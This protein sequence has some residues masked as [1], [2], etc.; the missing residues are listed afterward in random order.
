V[1]VL[2]PCGVGRRQSVELKK[3]ANKAIVVAPAVL[4]ASQFPSQFADAHGMIHKPATW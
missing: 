3:V 4:A 2:M 1:L